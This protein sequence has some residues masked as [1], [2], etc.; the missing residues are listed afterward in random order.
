MRDNFPKRPLGEPLHNLSKCNDVP[1]GFVHPLPVGKSRDLFVVAKG[2]LLLGIRAFVLFL[3][4][5]LANMGVSI[6]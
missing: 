6:L 4:N 5:H 3:Y 2:W 1:I